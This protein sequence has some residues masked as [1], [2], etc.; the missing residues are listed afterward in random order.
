MGEASGPAN[1]A[2][3]AVRRARV[4]YGLATDAF[5]GDP[6]APLPGLSIGGAFGGGAGLSVAAMSAGLQSAVNAASAAGA[7]G[8]SAGFREWGSGVGLRSLHDSWQ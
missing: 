4:A 1:S 3:M 6:I 2:A 7:P 5:R 8:A